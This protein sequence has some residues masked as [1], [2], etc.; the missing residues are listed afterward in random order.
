MTEII[1][2]IR[3]IRMGLESIKIRR[4]RPK[5]IQDRVKL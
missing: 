3:A 4:T 5:K 2:A 1:R